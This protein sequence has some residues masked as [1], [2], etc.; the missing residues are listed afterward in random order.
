M[1]STTVKGWKRMGR[2]PGIDRGKRT[3]IEMQLSVFLPTCKDVYAAMN[4][5][6]ENVGGRFIG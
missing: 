1:L 4:I 3:L 2:F 5:S 6:N